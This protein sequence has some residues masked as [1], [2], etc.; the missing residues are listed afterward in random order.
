MVVAGYYSF[1]LDVCQ[2]YVLP[3]VFLFQVDVIGFSPNDTSID[4]V[5]IWFGIANGEIL[6]I[7]DRVICLPNVHIFVSRQ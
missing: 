6:S 1:A 5:N 3:S 4:I 2:S 7:F